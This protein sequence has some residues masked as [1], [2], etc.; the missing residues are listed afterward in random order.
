MKH[1]N[2]YYVL[3]EKN[4]PNIDK[5]PQKWDIYL[6]KAS[7]KMRKGVNSMSGFVSESSEQK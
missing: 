4:L 5:N 6:E 2:K 7:Q 3:E 1:K